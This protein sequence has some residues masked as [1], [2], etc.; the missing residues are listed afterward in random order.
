[1]SNKK[2]SPRPAPDTKIVSKHIPDAVKEVL[3]EAAIEQIE[4][5]YN[6]K[7]DLEVKA[8]LQHQDTV[9]TEKLQTLISDIDKVTTLKL[10]RLIE[11]IDRTHSQKLINL[12]KRF[13]RTLKTDATLFKENVITKVSN[14]LDLYIHDVLPVKEIE[15]ASRNVRAYEV[16]KN[17][18]E[19]LA[20]DSAL[21]K[22]SI[23]GAVIEGKAKLDEATKTAE[24][25][26]SENTKLKEQ[27]NRVSARDTLLEKTNS[28]PPKKR[29]FINSL[30]K[31]KSAK[32]INE[33]F[34][35]AVRLYDKKE[36]EQLTSLKEEAMSKRVVKVTTNPN[37]QQ[38]LVNEQAPRKGN[39]GNTEISEYVEL[40]EKTF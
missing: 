4:R 29:G 37:P 14:Y 30:F 7:V 18:R 28:L 38:G 3:G 19:T 40:L 35:H 25:L 9:Y 31:G 39:G 15:Q 8:A 22:K 5:T 24:E 10:K 21:I 16:L 32:F 2:K 26:I 17:L 11:Q 34:E 33:N 13:K 27:L 23:R 20:V 36:R 1:M 12:S 6:E